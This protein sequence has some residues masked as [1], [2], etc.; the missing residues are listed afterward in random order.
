MIPFKSHLI[1]NGLMCGFLRELPMLNEAKLL[2]LLMSQD[3]RL[4][5]ESQEIVE[6][7]FH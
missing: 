4:S 5:A 2:I 3:R 7:G 1:L 6:I